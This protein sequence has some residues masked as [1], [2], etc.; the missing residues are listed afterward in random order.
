MTVPCLAQLLSETVRIPCTVIGDIRS[1]NY[2]YAKSFGGKKV[3][4][5][6]SLKQFDRSEI[7]DHMCW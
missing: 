5:F 6:T 3:C 1:E 4:I 2:R 7:C